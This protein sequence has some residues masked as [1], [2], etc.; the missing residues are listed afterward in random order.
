MVF[1]VQIGGDG[2]DRAA[3]AAQDGPFRERFQRPNRRLV[4]AQFFV[5]LGAGIELAAA[6][7]ADGHDVERGMP[8]GA[9]A[10]GVQFD[11]K[12][13]MAVDEPHGRKGM[14]RPKG[15][16]PPTP[17]SEDQCSIH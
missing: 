12:N 2:M 7:V 8:V 15:F 9:A 10:L 13:G 6:G 14:A 5:A 4:A 11:P 3:G 17:G 1:A 16:E